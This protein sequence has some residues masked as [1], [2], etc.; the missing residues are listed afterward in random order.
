MGRGHF[1]FYAF[2]PSL[3]LDREGMRFKTVCSMFNRGVMIVAAIILLVI[4][5]M[6]VLIL[7]VG[8]YQRNRKRKLSDSLHEDNGLHEWEDIDEIP[9]LTLGMRQT[10]PND[11]MQPPAVA[12]PTQQNRPD[13]PWSTGELTDDELTKSSALPKQDSNNDVQPF[14]GFSE[15]EHKNTRFL[16]NRAARYVYDQG[17]GKRLDRLLSDA[18]SFKK[19]SD[20]KRDAVV[21]KNY[22]NVLSKINVFAAAHGRKRTAYKTI[23]THLVA[24]VSEVNAQTSVLKTV[25]WTGDWHPFSVQ[26]TNLLAMF[27]LNPKAEKSDHRNRIINT[28]LAIIETPCK[29]FNKH[30]SGVY[31]VSMAAPWILAKY[32]KGDIDTAAEHADYKYA[33]SV[34]QLNT[35]RS[36]YKCG[37]HQD[38]SY[39]SSE[40][41]LK[42]D[43]L[44][45]MIEP[46]V[47]LLAHFDNQADTRSVHVA[48]Q[49]IKGILLHPTIGY[50]SAGLFGRA[51]TL[52][53]ETNHKSELG[54]QVMP[55]AKILRMFTKHAKFSVRGQT[56]ELGA[57]ESD[58]HIN[59]MAQFWIQHRFAFTLTSNPDM[60]TASSFPQ[61]G[62][63]FDE[64]VTQLKPLYCPPKTSTC[65]FHVDKDIT[66]S[67]VYAYKG[68]GRLQQTYLIDQLISQC[69][70]D[71]TITTLEKT[72]CVLIYVKIKNKRPRGSCSVIYKSYALDPK[73]IDP[74]TELDIL[75]QI[76]MKTG[77]GKDIDHVT[78]NTAMTAAGVEDYS[79]M[80]VVGVYDPT[81]DTPIAYRYGT[82]VA[83][84]NQPVL[85][86]CDYIA[87]ELTEILVSPTKDNPNGKQMYRFN[88]KCNQYELVK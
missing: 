69:E 10:P 23:E 11:F 87:S 17:V 32:W 37:Y 19:K 38:G 16:I 61:P 71:E 39:I 60:V 55:H 24:I 54:I 57:Y 48:L 14:L 36:A 63:I 46:A 47:E 80:D 25:P 3:K 79:Y 52:I 68:V 44:Q 20:W 1:C 26:L 33:L 35:V 56:S 30:H 9:P 42:F 28:I 75:M 70:I 81:T 88:E 58:Q 4:L 15:L 86:T 6:I 21:F 82:I 59:N 53:C 85:F 76:D 41:S 45:R 64:G 5:T 12:P 51:G 66:R 29:S 34:L 31:A 43:G 49:R 18:N 65:L 22:L 27:T 78:F 73:K 2:R 84:K 62:F 72:N 77:A 74:G 13:T 67:Y 83:Y 40:H 7:K 50:G 8:I